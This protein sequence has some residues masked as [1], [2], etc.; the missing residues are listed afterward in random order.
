M[1]TVFTDT[2]SGQKMLKKMRWRNMFE[3]KHTLQVSTFD[4]IHIHVSCFIA[5]G[6]VAVGTFKLLEII[7]G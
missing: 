1:E 6:V 4:L 7:F 2:L 5:G 3:K